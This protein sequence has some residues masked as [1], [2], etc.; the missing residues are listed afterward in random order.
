VVFERGGDCTDTFFV[1]EG[2]IR[3]DTSNAD[4]DTAF[5]YYRHPGQ[6]IGWWASVTGM[7]HPNT[8]TAVGDVVLG[9]LAAQEFM[10]LV[11]SRR[12]LSAWML[13]F[14]TTTLRA[15]S[16]RIRYLT[17]M[18]APRR[19][20]AGLLEYVTES[21]NSVV[22]VPERDE[23]ASR[24]GMTRETL[25]R[26]LSDLQKRGLIKVQGQR[27]TILQLDKLIEFTD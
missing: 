3:I 15:E 27:I 21:K 8:A 14:A 10:E 18:D 11:L 23:L 19:V 26:N 1:F 20:A 25:A 9:R 4:G 24:I 22:E 16:N 6:M 2:R 5:F 7:R 12:E 13:K 17:I